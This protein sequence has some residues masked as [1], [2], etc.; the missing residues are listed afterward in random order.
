MQPGVYDDI[1]ED[2]REEVSAD[3][4]FVVVVRGS[5]GSGFSYCA[6]KDFAELNKVAEIFETLAAQLRKD[7]AGN[8]EI[9]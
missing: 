8:N 9:N 6:S 3:A 1:C 2:F 7:L 5:K 4:A